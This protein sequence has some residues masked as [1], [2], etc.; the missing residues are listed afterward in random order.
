MVDLSSRLAMPRA[1][2]QQISQGG[3]GP[4]HHCQRSIKMKRF[5]CQGGVGKKIGAM[6]ILLSRLLGCGVAV[7][8][9][10]TLEGIMKN[11]EQV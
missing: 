9:L 6:L 5:F 1:D 11:D 3:D 7:G 4:T 2:L 10:Q 8:G